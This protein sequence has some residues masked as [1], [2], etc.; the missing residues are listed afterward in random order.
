METVKRA[1]ST[2][3]VCRLPT[4]RRNSSCMTVNQQPQFYTSRGSSSCV[5]NVLASRQQLAVACTSN[6]PTIVLAAAG[7]VQ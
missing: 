3:N 7:G 6:A 2:G 1:Y 5:R 4:T